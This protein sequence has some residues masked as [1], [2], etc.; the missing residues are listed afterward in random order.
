MYVYELVGYCKHHN[1]TYIRTYILV[2][3]FPQLS[4]VGEQKEL[5]VSDYQQQQSCEN[6]IPCKVT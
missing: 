2:L 6:H 3:T 5:L 1:C 4:P